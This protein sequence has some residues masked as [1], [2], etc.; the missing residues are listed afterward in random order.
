MRDIEER[1]NASRNL[2]RKPDF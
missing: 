2:V 1:K